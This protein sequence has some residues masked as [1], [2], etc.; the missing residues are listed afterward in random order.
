MLTYTPAAAG[1]QLAVVSGARALLVRMGDDAAT[2]AALWK[3]VSTGESIQAVVEVLASGGLFS[4]PPFALFQATAGTPGG[5]FDVTCIVR[6]DIPLELTTVSGSDSIDASGVST[7]VERTVPAVVAFRA[8]VPEASGA[9]TIVGAA[10]W[11]SSVAWTASDSDTAAAPAAVAAAPVSTPVVST[12]AAPPVA[13]PAA[14]PVVSPPPVAAPPVAPA[15]VAPPIAEPEPQQT[16]QIAEHTIAAQT[17]TSSA[18]DD[19][20]AAAAEPES[21][22]GGYDSLFEETMMRSIEDAAVRPPSDDEHAEAVPAAAPEAESS[23]DHDGMTVMSGDIAKLRASRKNR[24]AAAA[25]HDDSDAPVA[26]TLSLSTGGV[27]SLDDLALVGRSPSVSKVSGGQVPKLIAIPGD[28]DISRNHVQFA[29]EGGTVVVTDLHSRN[30]TTITL[31]GK[32]P[33][34]LRQGESTSVLVD[35]VVDLGGG[36]TITVGHA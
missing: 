21:P 1:S 18:I 26:Y 23:G 8:G 11:A 6:G 33:Q 32:P 29:V 15:V 20:I 16:T 13:P 35:T 34:L 17:V 12:P 2:T 19:M 4:T 27:E 10:A 9:L 31:P 28:Q 30:G 5:G 7:W 24:K 3:A 36:V 25:A 14:P 22:S